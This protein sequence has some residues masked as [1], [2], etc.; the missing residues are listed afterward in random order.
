MNSPPDPFTTAEYA[1]GFES[2]RCVVQHEAARAGSAAALARTLGIDA[3]PLRRFLAGADPSP[4][5]WRVLTDHARRIEGEKAL[6]PVGNLGFAVVAATLPVALRGEARLRMARALAL[7]YAEQG[8][9][10]PAWLTA[11]LEVAED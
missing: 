11:I 9:R 7:L 3:R 8:E 1:I 6:P 4:E 5:L 10:P 2:L